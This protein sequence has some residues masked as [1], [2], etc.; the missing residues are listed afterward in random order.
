MG[1]IGMVGGGGKPGRFEGSIVGRLLNLGSFTSFGTDP[2][3]PP[4]F[5]ISNLPTLQ[6]PKSPEAESF[7][8]LRTN[9][10]FSSL[11]KPIRNVVITS[12]APGEGKSFVAANLAVIMAQAGKRVVLVDADLRKPTQHKIFGLPNRVGFTDLVL[13]RSAEIAEATQPVPEQPNL[14]VITCGPIPPNPSELL[15]SRQSAFVIEQLAQ[16]A[17]IVIYDAAPA[18]A[19][20]DSVILATSMDAA[21][22]VIAAGKTR[23]DM[24]TR[25]KQTFQNV[26]VETL[27]PV[28]NQVKVGD[29]QGYYYYRYYGDDAQTTI[30]EP[31][32]AP[33]TNGTTSQNNS[34]RAKKAAEAAQASSSTIERIQR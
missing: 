8:V 6:D 11:D 21:I 10:Q 33:S 19:V 32:P 22:L 34:R 7:R 13:S 24:I 20:T 27:L 31:A 18:G 28:L 5:Q 1:V 23:K 2:S 3:N 16:Q 25:L 26:G 29:M 30:E 15:N 17:D 4:P 9:I 14:A 12:S